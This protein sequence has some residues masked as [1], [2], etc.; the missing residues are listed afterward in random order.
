MTRCGPA[1]RWIEILCADH[2]TDHRNGLIAQPQPEVG[3]VASDP[4]GAV[5]PAVGPEAGV[6]VGT[7]RDGRSSGNGVGEQRGL[8][9][10][11]ALAE[12]R[13]SRRASRGAQ[14]LDDTRRD[15]K[16]VSGDGTEASASSR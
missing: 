3:A 12:A 7:A 8:R 10:R 15:A 6:D 13:E 2:R 5:L 16:A 11:A 4:L 14:I 9:E 1:A